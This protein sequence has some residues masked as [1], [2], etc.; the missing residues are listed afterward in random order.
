M[1]AYGVAISSSDFCSYRRPAIT[2]AHLVLRWRLSEPHL[3]DRYPL[4]AGADR[5]AISELIPSESRHTDQ[6]LGCI[7]D[8]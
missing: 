4:W 3:V 1:I 6:I 7:L 8:P 5:P 2:W